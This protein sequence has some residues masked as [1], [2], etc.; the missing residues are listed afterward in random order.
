MSLSDTQQ[1]LKGPPCSCAWVLLLLTV[2]G[3][4]T[5]ED[6]LLILGNLCQC[7]ACT[8]PDTEAARQSPGL[9]ASLGLNLGSA[10]YWVVLG[11]FPNLSVPWIPL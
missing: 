8:V 5:Q 11:K 3:F 7:R 10:T 4:K 1:L 9:G 6:A 2:I